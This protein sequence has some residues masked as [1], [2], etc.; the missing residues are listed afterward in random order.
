MKTIVYLTINTVNKKI[1]VG[2]HDTDTDKFDGYLGNGVMENDNRS[3]ER[4]K[5]PFHFAVKKYGIKSFKRVTLQTFDNREDALELE[6]RIVNEKF[7]LRKDTYNIALGGGNPPRWNI[8]KCYQYDLNGNYIN[9]F[10][11]FMDASK[12]INS[13][14]STISNACKENM[15]SFG[16]YWSIDKFDKL[17]KEYMRRSHDNSCKYV[18]Q[19]DINGNYIKEYPTITIAAK[20]LNKEMNRIS[21][22]LKKG[23]I[24]DEYYFSFDKLDKFVGI[25]KYNSTKKPVHQYSLE[26]DFIRSFESCSEASRSLIY[27]NTSKI[28]SKAKKQGYA[29]GYLWS[30]EKLEKLNPYKRESSRTEYNQ[31]P[32]GLFDIDGNLVKRFDSCKDCYLEYPGFKHCLDKNRIAYKKYFFKTL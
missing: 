23:L 27:N 16:F 9:E 18:Y 4:C 7:I 19:Y 11:S 30:F 12:E 17:P 14:S 20:K 22:A 15:S 5:T 13:S 28:G 2:V 26:G 24:M 10:D 31:K 29:C 32:I 21:L 25:N 6:K 1:Y 8:I 3:Y